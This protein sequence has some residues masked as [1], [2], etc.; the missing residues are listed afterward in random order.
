MKTAA[1][2]PSE[3][4][5]RSS[6]LFTVGSSPKTSSPTS[7]AAMAARM[8]AVGLVTVS[9][10]RSITLSGIG[11]SLGFLPVF[12]EPAAADLAEEHLP[13]LDVF[14]LERRRLAAL[15]DFAL[16]QEAAEL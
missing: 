15:L 2:L 14:V 6:N 1:S 8:P 3:S 16:G 5:T 4:A 13:D 7:A 10:R 12:E 9:L 11:V